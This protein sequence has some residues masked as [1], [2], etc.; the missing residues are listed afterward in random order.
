MRTLS[1]CLLGYAGFMRYSE[2]AGLRRCDIMFCESYMKLF[3][4]KCKTD[5]YREGSWIYISK[6][7]SELCPVKNLILY[8]DIAKI[9]DESSEEFI[10]RAATVTKANPVGTLRKGKYLSYTR[11]RENWKVL[12]STN[13]TSAYTAPGPGV[14]HQQRTVEY[15]TDC[16]K[17]MDGG[18]PSQRKMVTS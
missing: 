16:S 12:V 6:T 5:V 17:D 18:S 9:T 3:I 7:E 13:D 11:M 15:R 14:Q 1:I 8:L 4:E 10:F 2:I